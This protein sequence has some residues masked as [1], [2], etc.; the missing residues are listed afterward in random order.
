MIDLIENE[1]DRSKKDDHNCKVLDQGKKLIPVSHSTEDAN[2]FSHAQMHERS[3][4]QTIAAY[5]SQQCAWL[6]K[7]RSDIMTR[8]LLLLTLSAEAMA[9]EVKQQQVESQSSGRAA[10]STWHRALDL[11][12]ACALRRRMV[13]LDNLVVHVLVNVDNGSLVT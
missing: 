6:G 3:V 11:C 12:D 9:A 10:L 8:Q 1:E 7:N 4:T 2:Y 13:K 5:P